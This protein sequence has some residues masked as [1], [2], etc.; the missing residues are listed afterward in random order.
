MSDKTLDL[1]RRAHKV[2][3]SASIVLVRDGEQTFNDIHD[4]L[5]GTDTVE[6]LDN[7]LTRLEK[8]DAELVELLKEA[9]PYAIGEMTYPDEWYDRAKK[10]LEA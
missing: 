6:G 10:Y 5:K 7:Q 1:L 8:R 2:L 4:Y 9:A 3:A